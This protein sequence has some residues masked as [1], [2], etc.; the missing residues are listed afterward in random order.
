[1]NE[2]NV[3]AL[4]AILQA[5]VVLD[6]PNEAFLQGLAEMLDAEGVVAGKR[7]FIGQVIKAIGLE[8]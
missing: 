7:E 4:L 1:M 5:K 2:R 3:A 8:S 6:P